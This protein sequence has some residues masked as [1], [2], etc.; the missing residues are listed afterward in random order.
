ML[1]PT[2]ITV[3]LCS[4]AVML[5]LVSLSLSCSSI[6]PAQKITHGSKKSPLQP[7]NV[8]PD[9]VYVDF[10]R[11]R[12]RSEHQ[13]LLQAFWDDPSTYEQDIPAPLRRQLAEQGIRIGIQG[14]TLSQSLARLLAIG[15]TK[16]EKTTLQQGPDSSVHPVNE[17]GIKAELLLSEPLV[18]Q[19]RYSFMPGKRWEVYPYDEIIPEVTLFWNDNGLCGR[20]FPKA[21]SMI[22]M[23]A[24]PLQGESG[25][26]F[27]LLPLLHYGDPKQ[28][29]RVSH[30]QIVQ[31]TAKSKKIF[32]DLKTSV[33]LLPGQWL[34]IGPTSEKPPG[35]GRYL[36]TQST[37]QPEQKLLVLR[38]A[39]SQ[40][41][42]AFN[43]SDLRG[44]T[45]PFSNNVPDDFPE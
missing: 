27:D 8:N 22:E 6:D 16:P 26:R 9:A 39:S 1:R 15:Q 25:V 32:E 38:L 34:L 11:I 36:L 42:S 3:Y 10:F 30:G 24:T 29:V 37:E 13:P 14:R 5:F 12:V 7:I 4:L 17:D 40:D 28:S 20:T 44:S 45:G 21:Q 19:S 18:Q 2:V 41:Q 35:L 33:R 23:T 43:V 31:E